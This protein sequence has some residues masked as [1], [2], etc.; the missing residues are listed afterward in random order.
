V[1][2]SRWEDVL[3]ALQLRFVLVHSNPN[4]DVYKTVIMTTQESVSNWV[5]HSILLGCHATSFPG[6]HL[7][8]LTHVHNNNNNNKDTIMSTTTISE[9]DDKIQE[10]EDLVTL[11]GSPYG[12]P[13]AGD[14]MGVEVVLEDE[15]ALPLYLVRTVGRARET[16][17]MAEVLEDMNEEGFGD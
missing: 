15:D 11:L 14:A 16:I 6:T 2:Q 10:A 12:I 9:H 1:P 4:S 17:N 5:W 13:L 3:K 8:I 7:I